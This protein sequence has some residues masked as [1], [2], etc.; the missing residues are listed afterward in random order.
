MTLKYLAAYNILKLIYNRYK[1]ISIPN[2]TGKRN[3]IQKYKS[4]K[5]QKSSS[6][7]S[8]LQLGQI[9]PQETPEVHFSW[10]H[11]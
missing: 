3:S 11:I 1:R 2:Y 4:T 9:Y 8:D 10:A 6:G 7:T 5:L